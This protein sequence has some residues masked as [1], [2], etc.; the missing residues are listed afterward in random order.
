M[1]WG[2]EGPGVFLGTS[3]NA[4]HPLG[5][6]PPWAA[7]PEGR[8]EE[9]RPGQSLKPRLSEPGYFEALWTSYVNILLFSL[10]TYSF[11]KYCLI[12]PL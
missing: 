9:P 11:N 6:G 7:P 5:A 12:Q 3:I 8:R 10:S 1:K 4:P 2:P